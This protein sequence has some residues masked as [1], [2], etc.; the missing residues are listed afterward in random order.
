MTKEMRV[1]K[2][3]SNCLKTKLVSI[4]QARIPNG[5]LPTLA[6]SCATNAQEAIE[7]WVYTSRLFDLL[8]WTDGNFES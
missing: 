3:S 5:V 4:A 2:D 1:Y 7:E 8:R 6:F